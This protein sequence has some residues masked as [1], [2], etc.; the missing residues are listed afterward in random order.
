MVQAVLCVGLAKLL[1][2][3]LADDPNVCRVPSRSS[4]SFPD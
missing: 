2:A 3:G 1:L 4:F